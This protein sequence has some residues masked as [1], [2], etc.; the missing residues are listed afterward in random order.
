[1]RR[2][3]QPGLEPDQHAGPPAAGPRGDRERA[4]DHRAHRLPAARRVG[5]RRCGVNEPGP[6]GDGTR[7]KVLIVEDEM[8]VQL[9][10]ARIVAELG[11]EVVGTADT[12]AE[13]L[14][15]ALRERPDLL[16]MDIHLAGK[17]DGVDTAARI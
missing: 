4:R 14:S 6:Q 9:H 10:L 3:E 7:R 2:L 12:T 15:L 13:A 1:D 11:H 8:I 5:S 17:D 16:L